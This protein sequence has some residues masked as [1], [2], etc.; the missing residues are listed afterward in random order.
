MTILCTKEQVGLFA[1][2]DHRSGIEI[3]RRACLV[4]VRVVDPDGD[5]WVG[6]T[7]DEEHGK[8]VVGDLVGWRWWA[9]DSRP[10]GAMTQ[11]ALAVVVSASGGASATDPY[12]AKVRP[13]RNSSYAQDGAFAASD[14]P[15]APGWPLPAAGT[16]LVSL[17]GTREN[18][19]EPVAA[20]G[21]PRLV[22]VHYQPKG[23]MGSRVVDMNP[24]GVLSRVRSARLQTGVRVGH[25]C[26]LPEA[27][28]TDRAWGVAWLLATTG[29]EKWAGL[30]LVYGDLNTDDDEKDPDE[31][32]TP[33]EPDVPP[34]VSPGTGPG[35]SEEN[36]PGPGFAGGPTGNESEQESGFRPGDQI[37]PGSREP[38]GPSAPAT[39][40][41]E[42]VGSSGP[43]G[44][45]LAAREAWGP[46]HLGHQADQHRWGGNDDGE[47]V[48]SLHLDPDRALWYRDKAHDAPLEFDRVPYGPVRAPY[49]VRAWIRYDQL[50][51]H[52]WAKG[53]RQ[54]L[55]RLEAECF[56]SNKNGGHNP[57]APPRTPDIP[58]VPPPPVEPPPT[59]PITP[60]RGP[61]TPGTP[62]FPGS[63]FPGYDGPRT[64]GVVPTSIRRGLTVRQLDRGSPEHDWVTYTPRTVGVAGMLFFP[65][66]LDDGG[67]DLRQ[68]APEDDTELFHD[69]DTRP[70]V[71]R[72]E[73]WG[74]QNG[75]SWTYGEDP[76]SSR[77]RGGTAAGGIV[78]MAPELDVADRADDMAPAGV[79]GSTA[80]V[81][82]APG[83]YL[84]FGVPGSG[85]DL[86][87]DGWRVGKSS[88]SLLLQQRASATWLTRVTIKTGGEI[89]VA[90]VQVNGTKVV[91]DRGPALTSASESHAIGDTGETVTRADI[92]AA[93]DALGARIN[94]VRDRLQATGGHGL[95][96]DTP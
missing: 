19:Q 78:Y 16:F 88:T 62:G 96:E 8:A 67:R 30:G 3:S 61:A 32:I 92:E 82:F 44:L 80:Y 31:A 71:L 48:N 43:R 13:V 91:G 7:F 64:G 84:G 86:D 76:T 69:L 45:A 56:W 26:E 59:G 23:V 49:R 4:G 81:A 5:D 21:D 79:T 6:Y 50:S 28:V 95:V 47:P 85:G 83:A 2:Q 63:D 87:D 72:V 29:Q 89:D 41:E 73:A 15:I 24:A 1:L 37:N 68:V 42:S 77:I 27:G 22:A 39:D 11:A 25:V 65:Q 60:P 40:D 36:D 20:W 14:Q 53:D 18:R 52:P 93:L 74:A 35:H 17:A 51:T 34:T 90:E 75:Q 46:L 54:G 10:M 38:Q 94:D 9:P 66:H 55:W 58:T 57:P 70:A 12:D 33:S